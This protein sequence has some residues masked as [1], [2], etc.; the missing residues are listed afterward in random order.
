LL[1]AQFTQSPA[2]AAQ[3]AVLDQWW[4]AGFG[5]AELESLVQDGLARNHDVAMALQRVAAARAGEQSQSARLNPTAT[6]QVGGVQNQTG[7]ADP[8]K[9]RVP[10]TRVLRAGLDVAWEIDLAGGIRAA[11][12]AAKSDAEASMAAMEGVRLLVASEVGRVY[13]DLRG[14]QE[15]LR[16]IEAMAAAQRQTAKHTQNRWRE[17]LASAFDV[18]RANAEADALDAQIPQ[19]RVLVGTTQSKLAV[20]LG[21]SPSS[22]VLTAD[23]RYR[24]PTSR[25][26]QPGQPADLLRRR[27]DLRAAEARVAAEGLRSEEARAQWWPKLFLSA[28]VGRQDLSLN[29]RDF[30]PVHFSNVALA[31]AA[32]LFNA[33]RIDAGIRLQ[34]ARA[35]EALLAWQKSILVAF[36]EVEDSLLVRSEQAQRVDALT[37]TV[38]YRRASLQRAESMHRE[39]QIDLMTLLDVQRSLLASELALSEGR[40]QQALAEVQLYK[41]LGGGL[42]PASEITAIRSTLPRTLP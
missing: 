34:T 8:V 20:L 14:A 27:P 12:D 18:D 10:D 39:G 15:R 13:F 33:G 7:L 24:W 28:L 35:Q 37:T 2:Q 3:T 22:A 1:P 16:I 31:L 6:L 4:W 25:T 32:P 9:Q 40:M 19:L 38:L 42:A 41:A 21:R 17:G 36:G 23:P 30:A 11:R 29:G 26:M 5:D